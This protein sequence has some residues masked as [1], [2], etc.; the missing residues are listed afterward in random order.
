MDALVL[1]QVTRPVV[2]ICGGC[3]AGETDRAI[4]TLPAHSDRS[5]LDSKGFI[6][7]AP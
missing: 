4:D 5:N 3:G 1:L 7:D 2:A 6:D